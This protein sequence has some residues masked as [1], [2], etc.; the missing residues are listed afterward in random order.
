MLFTEPTFLVLLLPVLFWFYWISP[1]RV[2]NALLA[3]ASLIFYA[4]GER[5]YA[6]IMVASIAVNYAVGLMLDPSRSARSRT[7]WMATGIVAN[8]GLL[9]FFKYAG[10][11][12]DNANGLIAALGFV[13]VAVPIV[14]LPIGISFFTFQSMSYLFDVYR[15][16]VSPQRRP[17][18]MALYIA[19]FP[20][21]IAGPIVRYQLVAE[22]L[23]KRIE[24]AALFDQGVRRFIVGFAKKMVIANTVAWPADQIFALPAD[25][26]TAGVAWLGITCYT[27]QIYFDFSGYSD[28]AIGLGRMFGFRFPENFNYPYIS[29]SIT[30]FWRRWHMTLSFW[31]RD[32]LYIP[33]G[34]NRGSTGRTYFNLVLVFFLCGLWHGANWAFVLWGTYHGAFL[35]MERAGL[36]KIIGRLPRL[37]THIYTMFVVMIGWVLFRI[38]TG[39][40]AW[41]DPAGHSMRYLGAMFGGGA[42]ESQRTVAEYADNVVWIAILIGLVA[43]TPIYG[44]LGQRTS[45]WLDQ[46]GPAE[47]PRWRIIRRLGVDGWLLLALA[48]GVLRMAADTYNPFIYFQF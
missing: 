18:D 35:V 41:G 5:E 7:L 14:H 32:Y 47:R 16:E 11:I 15:G 24:T 1:R 28:M 42:A 21:L 46:K 13:P 17:V 44:A 23:Q 43:A 29:R 38:A 40:P 19:L 33:L 48:Y 3:A 6:V 27:L 36:R 22:Q 31:F 37:A 25:E 30:E 20:Q 34:G 26:L 39:P 4:W 2:R 12:V 9:V 10:F 45:A 8:L